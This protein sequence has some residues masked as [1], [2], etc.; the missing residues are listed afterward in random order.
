M[1]LGNGEACVSLGDMMTAVNEFLAQ[2]LNIGRL[3]VIMAPVL[4]HSC[5]I[6]SVGLGIWLFRLLLFLGC[7]GT[8]IVLVVPEQL[9]SGMALRHWRWVFEHLY[10]A[11]ARWSGAVV[12]NALAEGAAPS[13][14]LRS[15][16]SDLHGA[17][18]RLR[19]QGS[20]GK[21]LG[22]S[23]DGWASIGG[24]DGGVVL[25][26]QRAADAKPAV[27]G[28]RAAPETYL[29]RVRDQSSR[30]DGAWLSFSAVTQLR[31]GGWCGAYREALSACPYKLIVDS[32]C[33][34]GTCKLLS[35]WPEL[36]PVTQRHCT[37][38]YL[39][40]QLC[41]S[42]S[43]LGHAPDGDAALMELEPAQQPQLTSRSQSKS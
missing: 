28:D 17:L 30:W 1:S 27:G 2:M 22:L 3:L 35:A 23:H 29:L 16:A 42:K 33:P 18:V 43:F 15:A 13:L 21:V 10:P 8:V 31:T 36:A 5:Y 14:L 12:P 7:A 9:F 19:E 4:I 32:G 40:Q 38:F 11:A 6:H 20:G 41:G 25:E 37:G 24:E 34:P 26:L 39:A